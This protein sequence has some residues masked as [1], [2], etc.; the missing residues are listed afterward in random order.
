MVTTVIGHM[1][2]CE[3]NGAPVALRPAML[4]EVVVDEVPEDTERPRT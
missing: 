2:V 1:E 3:V 4:A